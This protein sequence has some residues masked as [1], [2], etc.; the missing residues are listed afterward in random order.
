MGRAWFS[1]AVGAA[2]VCG[3][4]VERTM[5]IESR[6]PGAL[7]SL[8]DQEIGRTPASREFT[9]YGTYDVELRQE[10]YEPLRTSSKVWAPWWQIP[11][12]DLIA[13]LAPF[14]LQDNH[15]LVYAMQPP[16]TRQANPD[17][18]V[19][20]GER[21]R[22]QLESSARTKRPST[23]PAITKPRSSHTRAAATTSE[24]QTLPQGE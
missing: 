9:W 18:L 23:R 20:R 17:E 3:G 1:A 11:P 10:G 6:P 24:P 21:L 4:C 16:T 19:I 7:V 14:R 12:F 13:E 2:F 15:R 8:N 5:T 22:A